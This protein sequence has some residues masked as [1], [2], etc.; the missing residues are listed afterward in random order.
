MSK[1]IILGIAGGT[2]AVS[3]SIGL[4]QLFVLCCVVSFLTLAILE[5]A[6]IL[7]H[8]KERKSKVPKSHE[9]HPYFTS[10][11]HFLLSR[12]RYTSIIAR[13]SL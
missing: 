10:F 5:D 2:G 11:E 7:W 3:G 8:E 9:I 1:P 6:S 12:E 4:S 13:G